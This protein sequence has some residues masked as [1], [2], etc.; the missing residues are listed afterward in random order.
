MTAIHRRR[1]GVLRTDCTP[2]AL[3]FS[4]FAEDQRRAVDLA[5]AVE[6]MT[7]RDVALQM[8]V[9][10]ALNA[11]AQKL[12]GLMVSALASHCDYSATTVSCAP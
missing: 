10:R 4:E 3:Q 1:K 7:S 9:N 8:L 5:Q 12:L 2:A 6:P 11:Q